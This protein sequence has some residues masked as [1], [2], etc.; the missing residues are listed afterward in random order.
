MNNNG[1]GLW[2]WSPR[3]LVEAEIHCFRKSP[4]WMLR[5]FGEVEEN[6]MKTWNHVPPI[7][8]GKQVADNRQLK[9]RLIAPDGVERIG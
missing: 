6:W 5:R 1:D 2:R 9:K 8:F 7:E 4:V 3:K